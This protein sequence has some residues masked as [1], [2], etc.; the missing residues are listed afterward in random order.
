MHYLNRDGSAMAADP[1]WW[2][3]R[4]PVQRH[5]VH[6]QS[7][8]GRESIEIRSRSRLAG[9]HCADARLAHQSNPRL[10]QIC[11]SSLIGDSQELAVLGSHFA[12]VSLAKY[13]LH[14]FNDGWWERSC[15]FLQGAATFWNDRNAFFNLH[16]LFLRVVF[17]RYQ[18]CWMVFPNKQ[19][20]ELRATLSDRGLCCEAHWLTVSVRKV[21]MRI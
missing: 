14:G 5:A 3:H 10:C 4:W 8:P 7:S 16:R 15:G 21:R 1:L 2:P 11:D 20:V 13:H 9:G 12:T 6:L 19:L 18:S 17:W